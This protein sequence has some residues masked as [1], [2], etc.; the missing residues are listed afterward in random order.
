MS[1]NHGRAG[2]IATLLAENGK[3]VEDAFRRDVATKSDGTVDSDILE[4]LEIINSSSAY[5]I[6]ILFDPRGLETLTGRLVYS[7]ETLSD[8]YAD[9]GES[10]QVFLDMV[11]LILKEHED[12]TPNTNL[13]KHFDRYSEWFEE[14]TSQNIEQYRKGDVTIT[15]TDADGN[16]I[17]NAK[18]SVT[19]NTHE[20]NFGAN[21]FM[22]DEFETEEKNRIYREKFKE[23]FNMATLPFYWNAT[24]PEEGVFRF[25][26]DSP[27]LYRRPAIDL[28]MEYCEE[29]GI[30]P[31]E[32]GLVYNSWF[33]S[34]VNKNHT[35]EEEWALVEKRM[36]EISERYADKIPTIEVTNETFYGTSSISDIYNQDDFVEHSFTLAEEYFPNNTLCSNEGTSVWTK[37]AHISKY[38]KYVNEINTQ[39]KLIDAVG[40]QYHVFHANRDTLW[41]YA[42]ELY[43]PII[44]WH[45]MN[46]F[47]ELNI[48]E[49]HITEITIPAL[50][51]SPE[52]EQMQADLIE[53]LYT[54]WFAHPKVEEIVYWN[55]VDGYAHK[56]PIGDMTQGENVYYAGL[57]RFDMTPKPAYYTLKKLLYE[58]WH[59]EA[60]MM[61]SEDGNASFRGFY[62]DYT[63]E[64]EIDGFNNNSCAACWIEI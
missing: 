64:I 37:P 22:L 61:T 20:F 34:W 15:V 46:T 33:P 44:L 8:I 16:I 29:N 40:M 53:K 27:K 25:D 54:L 12:T 3:A 24:E 18:V 51:N 5:D 28:C 21:I 9:R 35:V 14:T 62:G 36:K 38:W 2:S 23:I 41:R 39:N 63:V 26:K 31:R 32:H 60:D 1:K 17:P 43:N 49:L 30:E 50:S 42:D 59:T 19:Q 45:T 55:L 11:S 10:A 6:G 57:I 7:E 48:D 13:L 47:A 4:M 56:A 52:D 58:T